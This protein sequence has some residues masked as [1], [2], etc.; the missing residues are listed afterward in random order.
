M[1]NAADSDHRGAVEALIEARAGSRKP[2]VHTSGSSIVADDAR[3][4]PC[5]AV[6]DELSLPE[7]TP[8]KAARV[9]IDEMV[10][11]SSDW[12]VRSVV[13]CNTLIYGHGRGPHRES[14]QLPALAS[15]ARTSGIARHV[16]R[17][18]NIWSTVH[19]DDVAELYLRALE[20]APAGSFLFAETGE[21]SFR[22]MVG[23]ISERVGTGAPHLGPLRTPSR[24]GALSGPSTP[25]G[26]IAA[27]GE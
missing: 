10:Q 27:F 21:A 6:Y 18:L 24:H 5:D 1:I 23:A 19:I 2:L 20:R 14:I 26:P 17:G 11:A 3:G 7:P 25:W 15:Q 16:G 8:D 9:A 4:E 12:G 13:L 22:D